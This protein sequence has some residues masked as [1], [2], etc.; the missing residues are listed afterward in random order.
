MSLNSQHVEK[1]L[2]MSRQ[3]HL[4]KCVEGV[5]FRLHSIDDNDVAKTKCDLACG[6]ALFKL[7]TILD[8]FC[9]L[10]W[11]Q[12][13]L[14]AE[15]ED[16]LSL[17][18]SIITSHGSF[19]HNATA[20]VIAEAY[21]HTTMQAI[22]MSQSRVERLEMMCGVPQES[23]LPVQFIIQQGTTTNQA[24]PPIILQDLELAIELNSFQRL[25]RHD[26]TSSEILRQRF[27]NF[28]KHTFRT[29]GLDLYIP[30]PKTVMGRIA[31]TALLRTVLEESKYRRLALSGNDLCLSLPLVFRYCKATNGH[32]EWLE[33][34][35]VTTG[36]RQYRDMLQ[37]LK[38][39][40]LEMEILPELY[41]AFSDPE[42]GNSCLRIIDTAG[43]DRKKE[44][45]WGIK[46]FEDRIESSGV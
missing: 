41:L 13:D 45:D 1:T 28:F 27:S 44:L 24:T 21:F 30:D 37:L 23:L 6:V 38:Y 17:W 32:L 34:D 40:R 16:Q 18:Q 3:K 8:A 22:R 26:G 25:H 36:A 33:I 43:E 7:A 12:F 9:N 19:S 39:L 15:T 31:E 35:W 5:D 46:Y 2:Q 20:T 42:A 4:A 29:E 11:I 14:K 10:E